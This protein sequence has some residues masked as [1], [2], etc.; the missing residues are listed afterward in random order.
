M[1]KKEKEAKG[2]ADKK[3]K[4]GKKGKGGETTQ[5]GSIAGHARA[6]A[7][8]RRTKG[9]AGL[10]GF[11]I[12]AFVSVQASVPM[13]QAG[14]RALGAGVVGYMLAWWVG[15][16]VW[17]QLILAEQKAAYEIIERRRSED[18]EPAGGEKPRTPQPTA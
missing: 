4:K 1:A 9:W 5:G 12:A 3:D 13:F 15:V 6:K 8:I 14:L 18:A 10:A 7:S 11:A 17:R 2:K 16:L